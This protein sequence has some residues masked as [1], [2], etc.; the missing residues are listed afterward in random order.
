M[1][2][3]FTTNVSQHSS[4]AT[5][6]ACTTSWSWSCCYNSKAFTL[7]CSIY[8]SSSSI[9]SMACW[10][11]WTYDILKNSCHSESIWRWLNKLICTGQSWETRTTNWIIW[12]SCIYS[13]STTGNTLSH[14]IPTRTCRSN[15]SILDVQEFD[16]KCI[17]FTIVKSTSMESMVA[18]LYYWYYSTTRRVDIKAGTWMVR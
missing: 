6:S 14:I 5:A 4:G 8:G 11:G 9:E 10:C 17:G 15:L 7:S 18:Q 13:Q 2:D 1:K 12:W 16:I 3:T